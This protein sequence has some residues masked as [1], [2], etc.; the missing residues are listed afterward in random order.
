[1][2]RVVHYSQQVIE[3]NRR[4]N[5]AH[6]QSESRSETSEIIA[7]Q[8]P[9]DILAGHAWRALSQRLASSVMQNIG[10]SRPAEN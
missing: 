3:K 9:P 10:I 5:E 2:S 4:G 8:E 7:A 6:L 1:M